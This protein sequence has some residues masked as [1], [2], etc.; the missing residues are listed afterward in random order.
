M[1][2]YDTALRVEKRALDALRLSISVEVEQVTQLEARHGQIAMALTDENKIALT[3]GLPGDA[4]AAKMRRER[5][6]VLEQAKHAHSRLA[7]L[8]G[9]AIEAY[10]TVR[11]I[12]GAAERFV[13]EADRAAASAEQARIDDLSAA[14]MIRAR[15]PRAGRLA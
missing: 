8:R 10:G 9:Q 7:A 2:P 11:A 6:N 1:T 13:E 12:E 3:H 4:W 5:A 14:R 15:R